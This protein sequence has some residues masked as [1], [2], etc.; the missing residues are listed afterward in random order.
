MLNGDP[1]ADAALTLAVVNPPTLYDQTG[2]VASVGRNGHVVSELE[3]TG[4][5]MRPFR[6][7]HLEQPVAPE[8]KERGSDDDGPTDRVLIDGR[9]VSSGHT[10]LQY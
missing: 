6:G 7:S 3:R 9:E 4:A 2:I 8:E 10:I 1:P 5:R